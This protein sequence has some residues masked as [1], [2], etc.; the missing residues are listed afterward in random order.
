MT[1]AALI[2]PFVGV[3]VG[4]IVLQRKEA[5]GDAERDMAR[6]ARV[7]AREMDSVVRSHTKL[8]EMLAERG[9]V[10]RAAETACGPTFDEVALFRPEFAGLGLVGLDGRLICAANTAYSAI[11]YEDRA[12][13]RAISRGAPSFR[14]QPLRDKLTGRTVVPYAVAVAGPSGALVSIL[15]SGIDLAKLRPTA[16]TALELPADVALAI[17]D[18]DGNVLLTTTAFAPPDR[19]VGAD[20]V[21]RLGQPVTH[22]RG[23]SSLGE[24]TIVGT[25]ALATMP[26]HAVALTPTGRVM[27]VGQ[28]RL[29]RTFALTLLLIAGA[30]GLA[31][32]LRHRLLRPIRALAQVSEGVAA[33]NLALRVPE[34]SGTTEF[35]R[36]EA[37]FN[38]MLERIQADQKAL[39]ESEGRIRTILEASSDPILVVDR[40]GTIR[41]ASQASERVLGWKADELVGRDLAVIQPPRLAGAHA[42]AFARHVETAERTLDWRAVETTA[43][44]RDGREIPVEISFGELSLDGEPGYAGFLRDISAR[45]EHERMLRE[46][47]DAL[48]RLLDVAPAMIWTSDAQGRTQ[49]V[50]P[51]LL[52]YVGMTLDQARGLGWLA[53]VHPEDR[54]RLAALVASRNQAPVA[55]TTEYRIRGVDGSY[56]WFQ[57]HGVPRRNASGAV[58]GSIGCVI[59]IDARIDTERGLRRQTAAYQVLTDV[60]VA[61]AGA[62]DPAALMQHVCDSIVAFGGMHAAWI[63]QVA[64]GALVPVASA[65][66]A[67]ALDGLPTAR[68]D[69]TDA[70]EGAPMLLAFRRGAPY[71]ANDRAADAAVRLERGP[72]L[73]AARAS[74]TLPILRDGAAVGTLT[75][76]AAEPDVFDAELVDLMAL[77]AGD[78]AFGLASIAERA[79]R[80]AA[81]ERLRALAV[82]LEERVAERTR[83]LE[84]ANR[85][86]EAFSYSVSHDLRAPLRAIHGFTE[87]ALED[88]GPSVDPAIRGYLDRVLSASR[89]MSTLIN[90]LLEL[91]GVTRAEITRCR[92]DVTAQ[93][94]EILAELAAGADDRDVAVDIAPG[95]AIEADPGLALTALTNVLGNAW[96]FTSR[97]P[98]ARIE[99]GATVLDG[100]PA[101]YVRDNGPGF[102]MAHAHKLFAPFQRLHTE[103][104]FEGTGIGLAIVQRIVARHGG[105]IAADAA[106][107]EGATITLSFG[108]RAAG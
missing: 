74:C 65:C 93:A 64:D 38:S 91:S 21:A 95:L 8:V 100:Q 94:R 18:R 2:V 63:H 34:V 36:I 41:Y 96:K 35:A 23:A 7:L 37:G 78:V 32:V 57:D 52:E 66:F 81:E 5:Q 43:R 76:V 19:H 29:E 80:S 87:L 62:T 44:R 58:E 33:G 106:P 88:A 6:Y 42:T 3:I 82:T 14:D 72:S 51:P 104:E 99:V 53:Y 83:S 16:S 30:A 40:R 97:T 103:R 45:R 101:V 28:A 61:I 11:S 60:N 86:L 67:N 92:V 75:V 85:E 13:F 27:A 105:R 77:I 59:D 98:G 56:R 55:F 89:R 71:V 25:A 49:Y 84:A 68:L 24:D 22:W 69:G 12:W 90:D 107:G 48:L 46:R 39:Q 4:D 26:W 70:Q 54:D 9:E 31:I 17:V 50:S 73:P 102:D 47:E 1:V 15:V 10:R 20:V 79:S 108:G